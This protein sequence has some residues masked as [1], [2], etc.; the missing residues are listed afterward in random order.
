M[1]MG[2]ATTPVDQRALTPERVMGIA[3]SP[4]RAHPPIDTRYLHLLP[5]PDNQ[6]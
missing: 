2:V 3:D 6:L 5:N 1:G 4:V